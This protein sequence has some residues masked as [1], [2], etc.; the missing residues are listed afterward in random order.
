MINARLHA[1]VAAYLDTLMAE[2]RP[3]P[4][5]RRQLDYSY[6]LTDDA[7]IL[8]KHARASETEVLVAVSVLKAIHTEDPDGWL[9][10]QMDDHGQWQPHEELVF[11]TE[12]ADLMTVAR[13]LV[14]LNDSIM[15][16]ALAV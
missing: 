9:L 12:L 11:T 4:S 14:G 8:L 2:I 5:E 16:M 3:L 7:F 1:R 13:L 6:Q 10:Y 15:P